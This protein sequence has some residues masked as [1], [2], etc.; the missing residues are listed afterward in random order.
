[1]SNVIIPVEELF[2]EWKGNGCCCTPSC[3]RGRVDKHMCC[4]TGFFWYPGLCG[5]G[6]S[7]PSGSMCCCQGF[8]PCAMCGPNIY[9]D[10]NSYLRI[11]KDGDTISVEPL[12]CGCG[13]G[14]VKVAAGG[15]PATEQMER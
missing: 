8:V 9:T 15:P 13:T 7:C 1:M 6:P 12:C 11:K 4:A 14:F 3:Y 5:C 10:C 2:G